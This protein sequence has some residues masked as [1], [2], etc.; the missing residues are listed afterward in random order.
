MASCSF[1]DGGDK[2]Y[3]RG[4]TGSFFSG[5]PGILNLFCC[6]F[7][8]GAMGSYHPHDR[9]GRNKSTSAFHISLASFG[10][11]L[12]SEG[13]LCHAGQHHGKLSMW[14]QALVGSR[15]GTLRRLLWRLNRSGNDRQQRCSTDEIVLLRIT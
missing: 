1:S 10:T 3:L 5:S 14:A 2:D 7:E 11:I 12:R 6:R 13:V 4:P 15:D 9:G 8:T